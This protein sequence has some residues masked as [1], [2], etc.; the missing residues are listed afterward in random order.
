MISEYTECRF[1]I[2]EITEAQQEYEK[3]NGFSATL[4]RLKDR[5]SFWYFD[6]MI[7]NRIADIDT[8]TLS[9]LSSDKKRKEYVD[10]LIQELL[11]TYKGYD[12]K[13]MFSKEKTRIKYLLE[14]KYT[15]TMS[16]IYN[17]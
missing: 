8:V 16:K 9:G 1:S 17:I 3:Y 11:T 4:N 14:D 12:I 13:K 10:K 5:M 2:E 6:T 15:Q 7:S